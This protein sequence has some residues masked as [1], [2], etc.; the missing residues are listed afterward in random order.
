MAYGCGLAVHKKVFSAPA[1]LVLGGGSCHRMAAEAVGKSDWRASWGAFLSCSRMR[2]FFLGF[3]G[4]GGSGCLRSRRGSPSPAGSGPSGGS[5]LR[6]GGA[7]ALAVATARS[8][9]LLGELVRHLVA[10]D[11]LCPGIQRTF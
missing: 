8:D 3:G 2:S 1:L 7:D 5:S 10:H 11:H 9:R 6:E 4:R